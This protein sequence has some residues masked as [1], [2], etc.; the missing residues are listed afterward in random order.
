MM[1]QLSFFI[2]GLLFGSFLNVVL[3]R[4][5]REE[6]WVTG[7]SKCLH[8]D[9][10]LSWYENIPL[11]SYLI[12]GG[13]CR[14]CKAHISWQYPLVELAAGVLF[15]FVA[16][17]FLD[18]NVISTWLTTSWLLVLGM[19]LI[20][21]FVSDWQSMEIPLSYLIEVN[22]ITAVYLLAHFFLFEGST[23]F[24]ETSLSQSIIGALIGWGFF[25][26]LVYF[27]RET[28][29]GWG[30]V[31]LGLLAGMSVGWRPLLPLLTL[32]FGLGAVYGVALLLVKGKNLKTAVP[33]AP[34]LVIAIL[35][36][37]FLGALYPSLFWFVL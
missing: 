8:C 35:G 10:V 37:L 29:M 12:L 15:V 16:R 23:P 5:E 3:F 4:A 22:I 7:R 18:L 26:G 20:L 21:I 27:S 34:F 14:S 32:A 17:V 24:S 9:R 13:R 30:D 25:F 2:L 31:W 33:F 19:F 6:S 28:W 36:T 11:L 1:F